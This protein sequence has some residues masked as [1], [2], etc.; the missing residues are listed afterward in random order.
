MNVFL[1]ISHT[2][3]DSTSGT[4]SFFK[5]PDFHTFP[6]A[7]LHSN[8]VLRVSV[9]SL[10]RCDIFNFTDEILAS[11]LRQLHSDG[12]NDKENKDLL[13]CVDESLRSPLK[14]KSC[15]KQLDPDHDLQTLNGNNFTNKQFLEC[16]KPSTSRTSNDEVLERNCDQYLLN[17]L[18]I[19]QP[20]DNVKG[21]FLKTRSLSEGT[22]GNSLQRQRNQQLQ[23]DKKDQAMCNSETK[24][25]RD[26]HLVHNYRV[27]TVAL[28]K[29]AMIQPMA[30]LSASDLIQ[31]PSLNCPF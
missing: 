26:F 16:D 4:C 25:V 14:K 28:F 1:R 30:L 19:S 7:N 6:L 22:H 10:P 5:E 11:K 8:R 15:R 27:C 24:K 9:Q 21:G 12:Y 2:G 20:E 3:E 29:Y 18:K 13:E 31:G 23:V 17:F